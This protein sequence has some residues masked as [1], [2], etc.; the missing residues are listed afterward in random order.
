MPVRAI[1][2]TQ[3]QAR[4]VTGIPPET[5]RHWRKIVPYLAH[6]SGKAA[7][8]TFSDLIGLAVTREIIDTFGV[9]ITTVQTGVETLFR[10]LAE[11]RPSLLQSGVVVMTA[12]TARLYRPDQPIKLE[13]SAPALVV[14]CRPHVDKMQKQ[15]LPGLSRDQQP[16]LP[17]LPRAVRR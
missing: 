8:F 6:R 2:F 4:A 14:P 7:R 12:T 9:S 11:S 10:V 16:G 17:F 3:E 1:Q 5:L 15:V 13:A